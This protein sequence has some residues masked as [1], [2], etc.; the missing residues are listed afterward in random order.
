MAST[1]MAAASRAVAAKTP[2]L[3]GQ[4]RAASASPLRVVAAAAN[5]RITMVRAMNW[6]TPGMRD[7]SY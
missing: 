1:I 6:N 3:S 4:S 5:G 7:T 2:F